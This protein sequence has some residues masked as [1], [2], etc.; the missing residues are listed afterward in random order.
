MLRL[1]SLSVR[2]F[3]KS[4]HAG[5]GRCLGAAFGGC[6]LGG[7]QVRI[8]WPL[9]FRAG[10]AQGRPMKAGWFEALVFD[11]HFGGQNC[12]SV[13]QALQAELVNLMAM[14]QNLRIQIG[15]CWLQCLIRRRSWW[16]ANLIFSGVCRRWR[17]FYWFPLRKPNA[18]GVAVG[19]C[20]DR[21]FKKLLRLRF[22][23]FREEVHLAIFLCNLPG[24]YLKWTLSFMFWCFSSSSQPW[25]PSPSSS[26]S[27]VIFT[28]HLHSRHDLP[29]YFLERNCDGWSFVQWRTAAASVTFLWF[30]LAGQRFVQ[31]WGVL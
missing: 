8:E 2:G 7:G 17:L 24:C 23:Q 19:M 26:S 3:F 15:V 14:R 1:P 6:I 5:I 21:G 30:V 18:C 27:W 11:P 28:R 16:F 12:L 10:A 13:A 4:Y 31:L 9:L 29:W 22:A 20:T 25:L